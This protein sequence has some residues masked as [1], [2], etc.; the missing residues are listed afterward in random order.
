[1][2]EINYREIGRRIRAA[3]KRQ[4]LTQEQASERCDITP[5]FYGNIERGDKKMSVETL[6]KISKGLSVSADQLLFGEE[7]GEEQ[8]AMGILSQVREKG[9]LVQYK[10]YLDIM[11]AVSTIIDKL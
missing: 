11:K 7:M 1:M 2:S 6:V 3:R 10:K 9:D 5:S 4:G 8:S